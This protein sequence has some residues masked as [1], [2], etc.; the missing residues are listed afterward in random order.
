MQGINSL[1]IVILLVILTDRWLFVKVSG[2]TMLLLCA[3][4][5]RHSD[6]WC[7]IGSDEK[8]PLAKSYFLQ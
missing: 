8:V 5:L 6:L 3:V 2:L 4:G 1:Q 7:K